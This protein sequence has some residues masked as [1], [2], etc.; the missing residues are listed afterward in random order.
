MG[1]A[2]Y[3]GDC[4]GRLV[5]PCAAVSASTLFRGIA[6]TATS[7]GV[8]GDGWRGVINRWIGVWEV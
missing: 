4:D 3:G 7:E 2:W 8:C 5:L 1:G 6:T